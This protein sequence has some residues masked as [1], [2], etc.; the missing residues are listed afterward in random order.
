MLAADYDTLPGPM[1]AAVIRFFDH[2]EAWLLRVF[3]QGRAERSL[4][5]DGPPREA[6]RTLVG[7]LEGAMLLARPYGEPSR[8]QAAASQLLAS[9]ASAAP[10]ERA[11]VRDT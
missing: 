9:I 3:E 2:N 8:F 1:R 5:L 11:A 10:P 7:G 4:R 6:A